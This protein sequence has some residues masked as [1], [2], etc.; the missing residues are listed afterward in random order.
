VQMGQVTC[1]SDGGNETEGV[2]PPA[3]EAKS[4]EQG[5]VASVNSRGYASSTLGRIDGCK[6][7]APSKLR[8][9]RNGCAIQ[10]R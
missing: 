1:R 5:C 6:S 9:G 2:G 3:V 4:K 10:A 7:T 8:A